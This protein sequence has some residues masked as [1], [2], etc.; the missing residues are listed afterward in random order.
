MYLDKDAILKSLTKE[1]I[2]KLVISLGSLPPKLD[3]SSN[4]IFQTVCHG[5]DSYKLYYYH[6]SNGVYP[7]KIFHC[8]SGCGDTFGPIELIIRANRVKNKTI[9]FYQALRYLAEIT[10]HTIVATSESTV[11]Q[12]SLISDWDFIRKFNKKKDGAPQTFKAVN[13]NILEMFDYTPHEMFLDDHISRETLSEFEISYWGSTNQIVIPHRDKNHRLI[14]IRGRYIDEEDIANI[15]KYVPLCVE[16]TFLSHSLGNNLYGIHINQNK[17]KKCKKCLLLESE[18]GVMQNHSYF[19][20]DDFSLAVCG[21]NITKAQ[22]QLLINDLGVEEVI[23][24]FDKMFHENETYEEEIYRNRIY[25]KIEPLIPYCKVSLLWDKD[26]LLEYK[27][28][29]TDYGKETLLEL[30]DKKIEITMQDIQEAKE[31]T[32]T[33]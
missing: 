27:Q 19:G 9:T 25:K 12:S 11:S 3:S 33:I 14:G 5:G 15:G 31:R 22:I 20:S 28:A 7:E 10:G 2:T 24:G 29:P 4:L 8:Y 6:E 32:L 26:E 21:S 17:I 1:D 16:G 13:E 30:L 18:K 23:V